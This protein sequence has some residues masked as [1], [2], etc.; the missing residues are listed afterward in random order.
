ME[1]HAKQVQP[2]P[3]GPGGKNTL[4]SQMNDTNTKLTMLAAQADAN[5]VYDPPGPKPVTEQKIEPFCSSDDSLAPLIAAIG[6]LLIVYG[7]A[8]K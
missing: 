7:L 5:T 4:K 3:I 2:L 8:S 6:C 1:F